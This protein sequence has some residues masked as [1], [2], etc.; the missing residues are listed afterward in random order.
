M[1]VLL[2]IKLNLTFFIL[3]SQT[4]NSI[5]LEKF[6]DTKFPFQ[7]TSNTESRH[8]LFNEYLAKENEE[9]KEL[10]LDKICADTSF[11]NQ[12]RQINLT[13]DDIEGYY[14][15]MKIKLNDSIY[16]LFHNEYK[17]NLVFTSYL[18]TYNKSQKKIINSIPFYHNYFCQKYIT[19]KIDKRNIT[20][21]TSEITEKSSKQYKSKIDHYSISNNGIIKL[22]KTEPNIIE[23]YRIEYLDCDGSKL[24]LEKTIIDKR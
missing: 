6:H 12:I 16:I 3:F 9:E 23:Y 2:S 7:I 11:I 22:I 20:I 10:I 17:N 19:G 24:K 1:K 5:H 21:K 18:S 15:S 8:P 13:S 14:Y 4:N